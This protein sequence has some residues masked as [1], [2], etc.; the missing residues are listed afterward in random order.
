MF[1]TYK[2][3]RLN[4][5][6][7]ICYAKSVS[8][9]EQGNIEPGYNID[10]KFNVNYLP[11][12]GIG[13]S[14]SFTYALT[15]ADPLCKYITLD[16]EPIKIDFGGMFIN[17]GYLRKYSFN[18]EPNKPL[19]INAEIVFFDTLTGAFTPSYGLASEIETLNSADVSISN[20]L[21]SWTSNIYG[22][23]N[24]TYQYDVPIEP[25]YLIGD[26][27]PSRVVFG[28]RNV[29]L[30]ISSD[31]IDPFLSIS[32][33]QASLRVKLN[34]PT[35]SGVYQNIDVKG[36]VKQ[37][38]FNTSSEGLLNSSFSIVQNN[39]ETF[40]DLNLD[41]KQNTP[42]ATIYNVNPLS[43]YY[44]TSVSITGNNLDYVSAV[45][46]GNIFPVFQKINKNNIVFSMPN[47]ATSGPITLYT[48]TNNIE[49]RDPFF[50]GGL[51]IT[52]DTISQFIGNVGDNIVISGS[53]FYEISKVLFN[54]APSSNFSVLSPDVIEA[55]IPDDASWGYISV[56]SEV[57][58]ISGINDI[59]FVPVPRIDGFYLTSGFTGMS[60]TISGHGF[61]GITGVK[62][63]NLPTGSNGLFSIVGNT[64]I[65]L[66]IPSGNTKGI[67]KLYGQS[68]VS[69]T[70]IQ[71]FYPYALITGFSTLSG[72]TGTYLEISGTNFLPELIYAFGSNRYAV[73]FNGGISG[74]FAFKNTTV[75]SGLIPSGAKSGIV[76]IVSPSL[77]YYPSSFNFLVRNE[78]PTISYIS[79][80]SGKRN[81][82]I[83]II[84]TNLSDIRNLYI[85]GLNT[86]VNIPASQ[87]YTST[88][89]NILNFQIPS[90]ITG[91]KYNIIIS[92][93]EGSV[94]GSGLYESGLS[95]LENP[96]V[97]GFQPTSGGFGTLITLS[98]LNIYPLLTQIWID[99]SGTNAQLS[100]GES[101]YSSNNSQFYIPNGLSS[102]NHRIIVY[103]TVSSGSGNYPFRYIPSPSISGF[104]PISGQWGDII[105]VSGNYLDLVNS[106]SLDNMTTANFSIIGSTGL[107]FYIP[108]DSA[109]NYLKLSN[110]FGDAY[111]QSLLKI[112]PPLPVFSGFTS[113]PSYFGSGLLITGAYLNSV[114]DIQFSGSG[115]FISVDTFTSINNSGLY[116]TVPG[117]ILDGK[118]RLVNLA[119]YVYSN[120]I[121]TLITGARID[122]INNYSGIYGDSLFISGI[123]LSGSVPFFSFTG[124]INVVA[125]N[126]STVGDTGLYF[127][128]PH[129]IVSSQIMV[130]GR[131]KVAAYTSG[132]FIVFPTISGISGSSFST[133]GYITITGI[134]AYEA[135]GLF[136]SG[137][138]SGNNTNYYDIQYYPGYTGDFTYLSGVNNKNG[139]TLIK[140]RI[141]NTFAGS[142]RMFLSSI[143]DSTILQNITG[144]LTYYNKDKLT[145]PLFTTITQPSP[146]INSFSPTGGANNSFITING[147]NLLSVTNIVFSIGGV[148]GTGAL[149]SSNNNTIVITP[150][151]MVSGT[152]QFFVNTIFGSVSSGAFRILPRLYISGYYPTQGHTGDYIRISGSG[153]LSITGVNFGGTNANFIKID[154]LG[155]TIISG[156]VPSGYNCCPTAVTICVTNEGESYCL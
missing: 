106:V 55:K 47:G 79:P 67:I 61:S 91:G 141:G 156:V 115:Q 105:R 147:N 4:I 146:T 152:G 98:G 39:L 44:G 56:V 93:M 3:C 85:T 116:T 137:R 7:S 110:N 102:G 83:S 54:D 65:L 23:T 92:A 26:T 96:Y 60:V 101:N 82:Y 52:I 81:D 151:T 33:H 12:D 70:S 36:L 63:N 42:K 94:T 53:N 135:S 29:S 5:N 128:V 150:P 49:S 120:Q 138:I 131:N 68:G 51:P 122:R 19:S 59:K 58:N 50:I 124:D 114:R 74:L 78:P 125:D 77:D 132:D 24:L 62:V 10:G 144:G 119:G 17:S 13:G 6:D 90:G 22:I 153:L 143:N 145:F 88:T 21:G 14:I 130:I 28:K 25:Q 69:A 129:E 142:G 46:I 37:T 48:Q 140:A 148:S 66:T 18:L 27:V 87:I 155:T 112:V 64:G 38:N 40:N 108:N 16:E 11:N 30:D 113:N 75:I 121:F 45:S 107:L 118:I 117:G 100:T 99:G 57:F 133:G 34:H 89:Q 97:S 103:N 149:L 43:G 139:Y 8:I 154:E 9:S 73:S 109:T 41:V 127:T 80:N 72:R 2:N 84:G 126:I 31:K 134:N 104:N 123:G 111:S 76:N 32:G 86:G 95:I 136:I 35:N 1:H 20:F 71:S 15:G